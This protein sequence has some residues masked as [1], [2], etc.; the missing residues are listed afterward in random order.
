MKLPSLLALLPIA[1][2]AQPSTPAT[3]PGPSPHPT[4]ADAAPDA[5][6]SFAALPATFLEEKGTAAQ[7]KVAL[8]RMLF[9]ENRLSKNHD[10]SCNSCHDLAKFGVDGQQFSTG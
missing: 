9:Y 2:L 4:S 5:L 3:P 7:A 8:G 1:A 10:V 6:A